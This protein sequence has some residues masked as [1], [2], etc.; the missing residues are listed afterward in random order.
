M[1][2]TN[3]VFSIFKMEKAKQLNSFLKQLKLD[4]KTVDRYFKIHRTVIEMLEAR[5]YQITKAE[6]DS[7]QDMMSFIR[8]LIDKKQLDNKDLLEKLVLKLLE[9]KV[10]IDETKYEIFLENSLPSLL[11]EEDL[12]LNKIINS[13]KST[14]K[15]NPKNQKNLEQ[16]IN[17]RLESM[18]TKNW[19]NQKEIDTL[20]SLNELYKKPNGSSLHTYYHSN[21]EK[22]LS[23]IAIEISKLKEKTQIQDILFIMDEPLG[24][25]AIEELKKFKTVR[26]SI[27]LGDHLLFN[28]T[29]HFLVPK[30]QLLTKEEANQLIS[31]EKN[32]LRKLPI[33][34]ET[35]P[36]SRFYDARPGDI[37]KITRENLSDD[38]MVRFSEF[39]RYVTTE[40][41]K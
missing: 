29:K 22:K 33:I 1:S 25:Q 4:I 28:I 10:L 18:P 7:T 3:K 21:T 8:F 23:Q 12:N 32:L 20:D 41:K 27:F 40:V 6:L 31:T 36:I 13:L 5:G 24:S 30:H 2:I 35:D 14:F 37:F 19:Y 38:G 9:D 26:I 17:E 39:Y 34:F 15:I 11:E 16:V